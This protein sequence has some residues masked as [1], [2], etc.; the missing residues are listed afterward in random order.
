MDYSDMETAFQQM[1]KAF[2]LI[3]S[4]SAQEEVNNELIKATAI[5]EK[6]LEESSNNNKARINESITS[7]LYYNIAVAYWWMH[8]FT[9]AH[10]YAEKALKFNET[11]SKPSSSG[12]KLIKN[13][14]E[15]MNDYENRL[16]INGEL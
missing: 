8:N 14:I 15:D 3:S 13:V 1:E 6:A 4:E 2:E 9:K 16:R 10:E 12:E 5:W 11:C 7:M